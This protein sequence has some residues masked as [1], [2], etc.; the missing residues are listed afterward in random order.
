M[1]NHLAIFIF[2]HFFRNTV[3][4]QIWQYVAFI[5]SFFLLS[6]LSLDCSSERRREPGGSDEIVSRG[7]AAEM[8][9]LSPGEC[10]M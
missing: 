6:L 1:T 10:R 4:K 2:F 5:Y 3:K 7:T 8:G 9:E